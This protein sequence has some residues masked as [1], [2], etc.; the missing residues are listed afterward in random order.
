MWTES[1]TLFLVVNI[2]LVREKILQPVTKF[3]LSL[4]L[5]NKR[6]FFKFRTIYNLN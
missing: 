5:N 6:H 4:N 2:F 1:R 3:I